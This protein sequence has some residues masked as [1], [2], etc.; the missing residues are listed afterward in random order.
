VQIKDDGSLSLFEHPAA[1][2]LK[3]DRKELK[4]RNWQ[5]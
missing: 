4:A 3:G 1:R 5:P 2:K